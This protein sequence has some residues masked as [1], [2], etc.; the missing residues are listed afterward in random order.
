MNPGIHNA[1]GG[2]S[3]DKVLFQAEFEEFTNDAE[4]ARPGLNPSPR[5][6]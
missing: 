6:F 2:I 5:M 1:P 3:Y 4:I